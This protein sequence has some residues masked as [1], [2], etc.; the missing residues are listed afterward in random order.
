LGKCGEKHGNAE[1]EHFRVRIQVPGERA[2]KKRGSGRSSPS[3][4]A[5]RR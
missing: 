5:G 1:N 3:E 2:R 4:K